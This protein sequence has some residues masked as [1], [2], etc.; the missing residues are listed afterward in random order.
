MKP[1]II[2]KTLSATLLV[3]SLAAHGA[4]DRTLEQS[5][6]TAPGTSVRIDIHSGPISVKVGEPGRVTLRVEQ[7]IAASSDA[8]ADEILSAFAV[9][10]LQTGD[11]IV[12]TSKRPQSGWSWFRS[13]VRSWGQS[14]L[15]LR[16]HLT[17]PAD[18]NL[19]LDTAGEAIR[20]DG[21]TTGSLRAD[22]SG[23]SI[24]VTGGSGKLNLDTAGGS[25]TVERALGALRA[26]TAGGSIRVGYVGPDASDVNCDTAGGDIDIGVDLA[27]K[28]NLNADTSGGRVTVEGLKF[29][30]T[31][32]NRTTARGTING[33][34]ARLLADT[35]GGNIT[36]T[37][38][39]E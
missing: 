13:W 29:E 28:F 37:A 38:A 24:K 8:A 32:Q 9:S 12:F 15:K 20:V 11:S 21:E 17:V 39:K 36:I 5:F 30:A 16:V 7:T 25:I 3:M 19:D 1:S 18:A 14:E 33:G 27:G 26:D 23:G 34:G 6:P 10:A 31:K 4:I 35:S 22:T 2:L